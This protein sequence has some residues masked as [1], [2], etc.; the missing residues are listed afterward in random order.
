VLHTP[1]SFFVVLG[2]SAESLDARFLI[3]VLLG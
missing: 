3:T 2:F 1:L